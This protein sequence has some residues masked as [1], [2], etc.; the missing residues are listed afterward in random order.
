[1]IIYL[2]SQAKERIRAD[3][4][5]APLSAGSSPTIES[6]PEPPRSPFALVMIDLDPGH[7]V[8]EKLRTGQAHA[9]QFD[10]FGRP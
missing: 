5:M 2:N 3:A 9:R 1:M 4:R 7:A 8:A 6:S 10:E